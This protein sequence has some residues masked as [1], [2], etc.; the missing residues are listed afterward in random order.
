MYFLRC[1][2]VYFRSSSPSFGA[3][4]LLIMVFLNDNKSAVVGKDFSSEREGHTK[5]GPSVK[6]LVT[7]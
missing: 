4:C 3:Y 7:Y 5:S 2:L 1:F 6:R